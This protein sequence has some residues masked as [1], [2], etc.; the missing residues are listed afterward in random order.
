MAS[1]N[2]CD[3]KCSCYKKTFPCCPLLQA[4]NEAL[5]P[6]LLLFWFG[7]AAGEILHLY[8]E[9]GRDGS[10]IGDQKLFCDGACQLYIVSKVQWHCLKAFIL[11]PENQR[12]NTVSVKSQSYP[13]DLD[14]INAPRTQAM[15][16]SPDTG[17]RVGNAQFLWFGSHQ[18]KNKWRVHPL[19]HT[20]CSHFWQLQLEK[21]TFQT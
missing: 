13:L 9:W 8:G 6:F 20:V 19:D 15:R 7:G 3:L 2:S 1:G 18:V 10:Q 14:V 5:V 11:S 21:D 17:Q 16:S 4:G 12:A